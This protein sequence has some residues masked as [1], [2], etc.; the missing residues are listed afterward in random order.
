L[1]AECGLWIRKAVGHFTWGLMG[2]TRR[3]LEESGAETK[4]DDD[5]PAQEVSEEKNASKR[6]KTI[7]VILWQRM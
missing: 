7:L 5:S 1:L 3:G 6:P 2:Q 4:L